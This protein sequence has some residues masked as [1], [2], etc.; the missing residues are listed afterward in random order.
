MAVTASPFLTRKDLMINPRRLG[1]IQYPYS[2]PLITT[3]KNPAT[4]ALVLPDNGFVVG[5]HRKARGGSLSNAQTY[6]DIMI[7]GSGTSAMKIPTER[8]VGIGVEPVETNRMNLQNWLGADLSGVV[9]DAA[10]GVHLPV[11]SLPIN[12]LSRVVLL[13]K[14]DYNGLACYIAWVGNR[15]NVSDTNEQSLTDAEVVSYP[16]TFNFEGA[17][18]LDDEPFYVEIFGPGWDAMQDAAVGGTGAG[19]GTAVASIS[20]TPPEATI[21]LSMDENQQLHVVDNNGV[22]RTAQAAYVSGTPGVA[23]VNSAGV[24]EAVSVGTSVITA[25]YNG[26]TDTTAVTVIA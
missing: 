3:I 1:V 26:F 25:T 19:F 2:T 22:D 16:Y 20:M 14:H 13:G 18:E 5:A 17:D 6:N 21:D 11:P 4:G 12:M 9:P 7:H 10:G 15:V 23:T 8:K 24:V